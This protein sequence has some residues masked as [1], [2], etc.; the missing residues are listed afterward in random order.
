M[1][2]ILLYCTEIVGTAMA[3]PAIRCWE[4]AKALSR[5]HEVTLSIPN[6]L[7]IT[8]QAFK[9][10]SRNRFPLKTILPHVDVVITQLLSRQMAWHAKRNGVHIIIDAYDPM[11]L[12]N[13]EL[14][15]GYPDRLQKFKN[16]RIVNNVRFAFDMADGILCAN[17]KQRDLWMGLL[18]GLGRITPKIYAN[19]KMLKNLIGIVPFGLPST[20][21]VKSQGGLR[22]M[23]NLKE[24]DKV[25]LWGGGIWNWFDPLSLIKAIKKLSEEGFPVKLV[26]MG[27]K[28]PNPEAPA[29]QM[30][31]NA[32][33]LAQGLELLDKHVFFNY[34]WTPYQERQ[35]FL[36]E[37]DIGVSIHSEHLETQ[38]AFRTRILDY[39]WAGLPILSTIGDS[40]AELIQC[41]QL[42]HVVPYGDVQAIAHA[43]RY[44]LE[45]E[46]KEQIQ[47]NLNKIRPEYCWESIVQ[48]IENMIA[49]FASQPKPSLTTRNLWKITSAC[50]IAYSP[51]AIFNYLRELQN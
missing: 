37:A 50:C 9:I 5:K 15:Q 46:V 7:E 45:P 49:Q 29:M 51:Q 20:A 6:E 43:I 17:S 34:G 32:I 19:D 10:K 21:P 11:P 1:A 8:S 44:L 42:G 16:T 4:L 12:E 23:F 14:F 40:F 38:Y 3:G 28:H 48:P 22:Q 33:Q 39:I 31:S 25:L 13:L 2:K 26:F 35:N 41:R 24:S 36:L 18:M 47:A 27:L 30:T